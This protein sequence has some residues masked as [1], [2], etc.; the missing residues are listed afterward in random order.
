MNDFIFKEKEYLKLIVGLIIL[1]ATIGVLCEVLEKSSPFIETFNF[2]KHICFGL[3]VQ[4]ILLSLS[5]SILSNLLNIGFERLLKNSLIISLLIT[6]ILIYSFEIDTHSSTLRDQ[7][8]E[9]LIDIVGALLISF[10]IWFMKSRYF[11]I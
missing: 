6:S 7:Y 3:F 5:I 11:R 2:I 4:I 9:I 1:S 10:F 8:V